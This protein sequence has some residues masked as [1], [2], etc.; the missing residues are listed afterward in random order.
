MVNEG[1]NEKCVHEMRE[2]GMLDDP[3]YV[4]DECGCAPSEWA[5]TVKDDHDDTED[6]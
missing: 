4:A 5:Y 2:D 6:V 1:C 3:S